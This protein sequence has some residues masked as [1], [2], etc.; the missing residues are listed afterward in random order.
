MAQGFI[1]AWR[2]SKNL[3]DRLHKILDIT[4]PELSEAS[5]RSSA[6]KGLE[7]SPSEM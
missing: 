7:S 6:L 1:E 5:E 3:V 4:F 2:C